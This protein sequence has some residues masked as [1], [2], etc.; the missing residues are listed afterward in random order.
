MFGKS[1]RFSV[2]Q[3]KCLVNLNVSLST[4]IQDL[5]NLNVSLS[6]SI[7]DLMN[8]ID[9]LQEQ[10]HAVALTT[11]S[12]ATGNQVTQVSSAAAPLS[13]RLVEAKMPPFLEKRITSMETQVLLC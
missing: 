7:Q 4:S 13:P 12:A 3:S 11:S 10:Q 1:Q 8:S 9:E 2:R 5:M 6:T